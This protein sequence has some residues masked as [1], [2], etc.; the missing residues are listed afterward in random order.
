MEMKSIGA[1]MMVLVLVLIGGAFIQEIA[2]DTHAA[3]NTQTNSNETVNVA[4]AHHLGK[5]LGWNETRAVVMDLADDDVASINQVRWSNGTVLVSGTDYVVAGYSTVN[6]ENITIKLYN[7]TSNFIHAPISNT[8]VVDYT[9]NPAEY[10]D[11]GTSRTLLNVFLPLFFILALV[12]SVL[13]I[14]FKDQLKD[15]LDNIR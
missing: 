13:G 2:N 6:T 10:V 14:V 1:I 11:D 7:T 12:L 4:L 9:Y 15:M 3:T 5:A 8:T